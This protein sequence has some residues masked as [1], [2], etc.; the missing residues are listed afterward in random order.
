MLPDHA[1]TDS[2]SWT[3]FLES[4]Q[5]SCDPAVLCRPESAEAVRDPGTTPRFF[6]CCMR[7]RRMHTPV[8]RTQPQLLTTVHIADIRFLLSF[9]PHHIIQHKSRLFLLVLPASFIFFSKNERL[10]Q[11]VQQPLFF[12]IRAFT[13]GSEIGKD[14]GERGSGNARILN[15]F[16]SFPEHDA[17]EQ[18]V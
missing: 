17:A 10:P 2:G 5:W 9:F 3:G 13:C 16:Y 4:G 8:F 12:K 1:H 15:G 7:P 14:D 18:R 6:A 11:L